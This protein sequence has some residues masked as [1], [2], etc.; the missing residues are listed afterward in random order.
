MAL[1]QD[2]IVEKIENI[3]HCKT[4]MKT[5]RDLKYLI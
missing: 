4:A 5:K 2:V 3:I 1:N